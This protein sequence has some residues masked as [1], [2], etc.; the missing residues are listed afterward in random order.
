MLP[1]IRMDVQGPLY[2]DNS[3][4]TQLLQGKIIL[5]ANIILIYVLKYIFLSSSILSI[6]LYMI[7]REM[8]NV[9]KNNI[10]TTIESIN[11]NLKK[12]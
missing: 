5:E 10:L 1:V 9:N 4:K 7:A 11:R 8:R 2:Q 6:S 3:N 12:C